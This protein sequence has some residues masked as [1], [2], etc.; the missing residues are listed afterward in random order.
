V[1]NL[2]AILVVARHQEGHR[3]LVR[4]EVRREVRKMKVVLH[5]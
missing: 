3:R 5:N 1:E 2:R 4:R